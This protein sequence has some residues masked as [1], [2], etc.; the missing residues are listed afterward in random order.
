MQLHAP[1][2]GDL[3]GLD[4]KKSIPVAA[5]LPGVFYRRAPLTSRNIAVSSGDARREGGSDASAAGGRISE[6]SE[7]QRSA[8]NAGIP[9]PRRTPGTA[10]GCKGGRLWCGSNQRSAPPRVG[11]LG[12]FSPKRESAAPGRDQ[13]LQI[14]RQA[15]L[16][17]G[18]IATPV[19]TSHWFAMT[20]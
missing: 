12:T 10:T 2:A 13:H 14:C 16:L 3:I 17:G 9:M 5:D 4:P 7:W 1:A 18:R 20:R 11:S 6:L 15:S 8:G 19:T